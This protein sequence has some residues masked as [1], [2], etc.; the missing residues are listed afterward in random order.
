MLNALFLNF[1]VLCTVTFVIGWTLRTVVLPQ[2]W[3]QIALR[4]LLTTASSFIL[5]VNAVPLQGGASLDL[6]AVP[7]ALATIGGGGLA[8]ATV[9]LPLM[10]YALWQGGGPGAVQV[11]HLALVVG[12]FALLRR[13]GTGSPETLGV[14]WWQPF[15]LFGG[16]NLPLALGALLTTHDALLAVSSVLLITAAQGVGTVAAQ[17][18]VLTELRASERANVLRD[19][20]YTDKLTG[21]GNRRAL[22]EVLARPVPGTHLLLLDLDHFKAVNDTYGHAGGDLVL[23]AV[24]AVLREVVGED[25]QVYRFGGEEFAV[26]FW[27]LTADQAGALAQDLRSQVAGQVGR[28]AGLP[29]LLVTLSAGLVALADSGTA[30]ERADALLYRAKRGGRDRVEAELAVPALLEPG[31]TRRGWTR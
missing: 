28:R 29:R 8:G 10:V 11:L 15:V 22:D 30:V 20:A 1:C 9:A 17:A 24:A 21:L 13:R 16:A 12:L 6:R 7:V 14:S 4:A 26:L 31:G 3:S 23:R 18:I 25:G 27:G 5:I 2:V 19:F